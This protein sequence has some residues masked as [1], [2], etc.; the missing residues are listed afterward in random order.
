MLTFYSG[1]RSNNK[2]LKK[3]IDNITIFALKKEIPDILDRKL[4]FNF[5][6]TK[7]LFNKEDVFGYTLY[8]FPNSYS[9]GLDICLDAK[10]FIRVLIHELIHCKQYIKKELKEINKNGKCLYIY[11]NKEYVFE[12]IT[13]QEWSENEWE[14]DALEQEDEYL[15]YIDKYCREDITCLHRLLH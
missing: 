1:F 15:K 9:I 6:F 11:K 13:K 7:N 4:N 12:Q 14:K 2:I 10:F 3:I 5:V 8:F